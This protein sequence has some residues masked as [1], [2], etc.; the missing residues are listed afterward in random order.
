MNCLGYLSD[1][2]HSCLHCGGVDQPDSPLKRSRFYVPP[3]NDPRFSDVHQSDDNDRTYASARNKAVRFL[4]ANRNWDV[5]PKSCPSGHW[6]MRYSTPTRTNFTPWTR[7]SPFGPFDLVPW[8]KQ[9]S[10]LD[11]ADAIGWDCETV[12]LQ[13]PPSRRS[14]SQSSSRR[15][16]LVRI[17]VVFSFEFHKRMRLN[18]QQHHQQ[19]QRSRLRHRAS[20]VRLAGGGRSWVLT[21][22][23]Q[24]QVFLFDPKVFRLSAD[25]LGYFSQR[26]SGVDELLNRGFSN[27]TFTSAAPLQTSRSDRMDYRTLF[28]KVSQLFFKDNADRQV[29]KQV[30][31]AGCRKRYILSCNTQNMIVFKSSKPTTMQSDAPMR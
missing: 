1:V 5:V 4:S 25:W 10:R 20:R 14:I 2:L 3:T 29:F 22:N 9:G 21:S 17:R 13:R 26:P 18:Q 12:R 30:P 11:L 23:H 19:L 15:R 7:E 28:G 31:C 8:R 16:R 24:R 27:H 6:T